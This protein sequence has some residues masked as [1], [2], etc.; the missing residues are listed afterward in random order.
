MKDIVVAIDPGLG[1]GIA[2]A[3]RG[4][5]GGI[6]F[7]CHPMPDTE[8]DLVDLLASLAY[9]QRATVYV[10][11]VPYAVGFAGPNRRMNP[12]SSAKLHRNVGVVHG[13]LLALGVRTL[14]VRPREW[15]GH[16]SLG[17]AKGHGSKWKSVLKAEAQRRFPGMRVT[18]A[19]AD[20]LLILDWALNR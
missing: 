3:D 16:Y 2:F 5:D 10:E 15:Q 11:D 7:G 4:P 6:K 17:T 9:G 18:L 19:T 12:A 1:G 8:K 13:A 20:A 14:L